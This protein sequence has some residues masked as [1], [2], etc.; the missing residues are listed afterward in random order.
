M[1]EIAL[2]HCLGRGLTTVERLKRRL[3]D[4]GG[5]GRRGTAVIQT[6]LSWRSPGQVPTASVFET[7]FFRILRSY[8]R[9]L[10][11]RQFVI[12]EK[13][14]FVAQVDFAFPESKLAIECES[15]EHHSDR[16]D[17]ERDVKRHNRLA[18]LGWRLLRVTWSDLADPQR[19]VAGIFPQ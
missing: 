9:P 5:S 11:D 10:P 1:V 4:L 6:L 19:L 8:R 18:G 7:K 3:E 13:G 17:W 15:F 14:N 12:T 2:E 16:S